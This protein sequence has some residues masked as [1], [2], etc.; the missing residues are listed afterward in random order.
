[1]VA[2]IGSH[3]L[4]HSGHVFLEYGVDLQRC[5]KVGLVKKNDESNRNEK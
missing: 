2:S 5:V 1:M 4:Y 3:V